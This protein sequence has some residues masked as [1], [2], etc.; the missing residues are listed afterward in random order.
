[1]KRTVK[2]KQN[3]NFPYKSKCTWKATNQKLDE[4]LG[5]WHGGEC[6]HPELRIGATP[7]RCADTS[8]RE[9]EAGTSEVHQILF[10]KTTIQKNLGSWR[11]GSLVRSSTRGLSSGMVAHVPGDTVPG[12]GRCRH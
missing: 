12:S 10:Q 9:V 4:G 5:L 2:N 11:D 1:M 8:I 6:S 3:Q 7:A